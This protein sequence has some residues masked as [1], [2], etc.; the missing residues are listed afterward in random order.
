M[1]RLSCFYN[2]T[3]YIKNRVADPSL[4]C[5]LMESRVVK[6]H[7][8][9]SSSVMREVFF[10]PSLVKFSQVK[11]TIINFKTTCFKSTFVIVQRCRLPLCNLEINSRQF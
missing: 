11:M 3:L 10:I 1:Y 7:A 8:I 6:L 4:I 9:I 5:Q 2:K